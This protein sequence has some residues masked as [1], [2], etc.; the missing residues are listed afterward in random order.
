MKINQLAIFF[1][2]FLRRNQVVRKIKALTG[3]S[4]NE[5]IRKVKIKN[6]MRLLLTGLYNISETTYM[7]GFSDVSYSSQCCKEEYDMPPSEYIKK[8][9][10]DDSLA[11][12]ETEGCVATP[13]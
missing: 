9:R 12:I 4:A 7:I 13:P 3:I 2:L 6:S 11:R 1:M 10:E 8:I 5:F